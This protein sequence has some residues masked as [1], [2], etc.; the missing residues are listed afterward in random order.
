MSAGSVW[1]GIDVGTQSVRAA[2]IDD[3]GEVLA[4][5]S[6]PLSSVRSGSR[7]EQDATHWFDAVLDS[8]AELIAGLRSAEA[9]TAVAVSA[10]SGTIVPVDAD[11]APLGPGV[12]YDDARGADVLEGVREAGADVWNRLG[13]RMQA[14]WAL[15]TLVSMLD[16]G[17]PEGAVLAHQADAVASL[18]VG[19]RVA[20]DTSHALKTGADLDAV[21]W[22]TDVLDRLG[23]DPAILP[24][25]VESGSV[26]G[27][28]APAVAERTG[29]TTGAL[30]VAGMTDG[31]AA[32][33]AAGALEPGAWNSVLGTTLVLKGVSRSRR[34]DP[35][36]TVYS[37]R[38][39]FDGGWFPGGASSTGAG[40]LS[41]LLPGRDLEMLTAGLDDA[42]IPVA[43]PLVGDG[44]RFPFVASDARGILDTGSDDAGLFAQVLFGTAFVERL[45]FDLVDLLGYPVDR[46]S[47]TGG[48][49]RNARWNRLRCDLL[50]MP[51]EVAPASEGATGMALLA[52]AAI[53]ADAAPDR[54]G[55]AGRRM[56][57]PGRGL[58][59][60]PPTHRRL[61]EAYA[62]FVDLLDARGWLAADLASH[63]RKR[64][65]A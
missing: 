20:A 14:S 4:S 33:L 58:D 54:L 41:A 36:G 28:I 11:G 7:H 6:R 60:D 8:I 30:V 26:V 34:P 55:R 38:A 31:C 57:R 44:E 42:E 9:V 29:L 21:A 35:G 27:R 37:H 10:T 1:L 61:E 59:P 17:W 12:M 47:F 23:I 45:S 53:D 39:P 13:Y 46:V 15:P 56:L 5:A 24:D 43:Y 52:A 51:V 3:D 48:G 49:A 40:A 2:A 18:L 22:P 25:L 64:L 63:A 32:Q 65:G 50:G 62:R 19:R 16:D